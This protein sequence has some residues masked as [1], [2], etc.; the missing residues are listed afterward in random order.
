MGDIGRKIIIG[1]D[2]MGGDYAPGEVVSGGIW[3][4]RENENIGILLIGR[5]NEIKK[6]MPSNVPENVEIY[7]APE[8]ISMDDPPAMSVRKKRKSSISIGAD[9]LKEGRINAFV[10]A[11]NTGAVVCAA[12]LKVKRLPG[13]ER[14][15]LAVV[16]P[17]VK[18]TPLMAIDVGANIDVKPIHLFQYALMSSVYY[19]LM[20]DYDK[21]PRVGLLNIGEEETKGIATYK[22]VSLMLKESSLNFIGNVEGKDLFKGEVDIVVMDGFVGNV[23]L[24]VSE[25]VADAVISLLKQEFKRASLLTKLGAFLFLRP[26]YMRLKK[27]I[28]YS[29]Y[30]GALLLGI[31]GVCVIAHGRSNARAIKNA[32]NVA[33][34][35]IERK[36]NDR[37]LQGLELCKKSE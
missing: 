21:D 24:K 7:D 23:V 14:P 25:G 4:A 13:I 1:L 15:G 22:E 18:G 11:G 28:D 9:L 26:P 10:S 19:K 33:V 37:I 36:V 3:A 8:V 31:N 12:T 29:E 27:K 32:V 35:E 20:W 34:K 17:T 2:A 30:G 5:Q 6:V 16:F